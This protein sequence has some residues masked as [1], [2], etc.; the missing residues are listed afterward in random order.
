VVRSSDI[1]A[2]DPD[3]SDEN[4]SPSLE[5]VYRHPSFYDIP[6]DIENM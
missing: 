2:S 1:T 5:K 3:F 4:F 6:D